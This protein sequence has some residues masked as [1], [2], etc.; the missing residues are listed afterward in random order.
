M[1]IK[2]ID[3]LALLARLELSQEEKESMRN[4]F[5]SILGYIDQIAQ[6]KID[7]IEP[8]YSL[9]NVMRED[10]LLNDDGMYTE[11]LV[12]EM[13]DKQDGYLKVKQI[14]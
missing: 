1:E 7:T 4:D 2:D 8:V 10:V 6:V 3:K 12:R 14:L 5:D 11:V 9:T 13:P